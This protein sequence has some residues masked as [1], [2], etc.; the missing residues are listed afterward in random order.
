MARV[1]W[2]VWKRLL[3]GRSLRMCDAQ[4]IRKKVDVAAPQREQAT[5]SV[6]TTTCGSNVIAGMLQ[7]SALNGERPDYCDGNHPV[8]L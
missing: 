3:H 5:G 6:I 1:L 7:N 4:A 2:K 8:S